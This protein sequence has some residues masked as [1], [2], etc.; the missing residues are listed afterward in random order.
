MQLAAHKW[1]GESTDAFPADQ[2]GALGL[3]VSAGEGKIVGCRH[4]LCAI[5]VVVVVPADGTI[6]AF[7]CLGAKFYIRESLPA[8]GCLGAFVFGL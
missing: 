1:R 8:L 3:S 6:C 4:G 2:N 5:M 7:A